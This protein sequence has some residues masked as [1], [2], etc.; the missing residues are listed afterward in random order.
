MSKRYKLYKEPEIRFVQFFSH[1]GSRSWKWSTSLL[2]MECQ[3]FRPSS[4]LKYSITYILESPMLKE[5]GVA[6][7]L[8]NGSSW[9]K[10]CKTRRWTGF[11]DKTEVLKGQLSSAGIGKGKQHICVE[12][13]L[14]LSRAVN[15]I[16][17]IVRNS[18]V[19]NG[20][21]CREYYIV[22]MVVPF[23]AAF[24]IVISGLLQNAPMT[25]VRTN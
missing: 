24:L 23:V 17:E 3:K 5:S 9:S 11:A 14:C 22:D 8:S 18:I 10:T 16:Q 1:H 13:G 6:Y 15:R 4:N 12:I 20:L 7:L 2:R 19:K 21:D 25:L